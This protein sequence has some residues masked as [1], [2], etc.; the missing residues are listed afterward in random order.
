MFHRSA[1]TEGVTNCKPNRYLAIV[2]LIAVLIGTVGGRLFVGCAKVNKIPSIAETATAATL[3]R[4]AY[5]NGVTTFGARELELGNKAW[6]NN[7]GFA[8]LIGAVARA[9]SE[10]KCEVANLV[11]LVIHGYRQEVVLIAKGLCIAVQYPV[12]VCADRGV[13]RYVDDVGCTLVCPVQRKGGFGARVNL[14]RLG[15]CEYA[16]VF[17]LYAIGSSK[18]FLGRVRVGVDVSNRGTYRGS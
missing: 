9:N 17:V 12:V 2:F 4:K 3:V 8:G 7:D 6:R 5:T 10:T 11:C 13:V 1:T 15:L 18:V 14:N 16:T